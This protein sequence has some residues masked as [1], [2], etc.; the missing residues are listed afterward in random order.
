MPTPPLPIEPTADSDKDYQP[1]AAGIYNN[2][3][4]CLAENKKCLLVMFAIIFGVSGIIIYITQV[5]ARQCKYTGTVKDDLFDLISTREF[6][7]Y[8][9]GANTM[10]SSLY[11]N[12]TVEFGEKCLDPKT[13][14]HTANIRAPKAGA[15]TKVNVTATSW[16]FQP[17]EAELYIRGGVDTI[18]FPVI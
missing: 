2:R 6:G 16:F 8:G 10:L 4:S 9:C 5:L 18:P 17:C 3:R 15:V 11:P 12:S 1:L 7:A 13:G 14:N